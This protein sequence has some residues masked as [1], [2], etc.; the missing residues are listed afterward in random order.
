MRK[1]RDNIINLFSF[2]LAEES[3]D[4]YSNFIFNV[5]V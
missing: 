1:L 4:V 2:G 5:F 3:W